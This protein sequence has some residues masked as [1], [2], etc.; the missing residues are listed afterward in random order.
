MDFLNNRKYFVSVNGHSY[1]T[2][3]SNIGV[4]QGSTLGP[5]F[6]LLYVN[7]IINCSNILKFILFADDTTIMYKH[8]NINEL[9]NILTNE[10]T[11][12]MNWFSAN[13]LLL[14]LSKSHT[15]LFSNKRGNPKLKVNIQ[16]MHLE[17][18]EV[19]TFLGVEIDNK[20]LWTSHIK[21]ICSKISKSIGILRRLRFSF[22]NH[23][24][25]MI[26]MSLIYSYI[27]YCNVVWGSA[28]QNHL[29][30][31]VILQKKSC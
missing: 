24:L 1:V 22:P 20:L 5:L 10:T 17:D 2:K 16:N 14:N 26:Y 25:K 7:D 18:K 9:N 28:Y 4:P 29:K 21:H 19:V 12:V 27:N 3:I 15:M 11:K 23:I 8:N 31:L 30:P 13:K 6:F